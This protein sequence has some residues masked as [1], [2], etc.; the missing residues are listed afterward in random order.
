MAEAVSE[1]FVK[2]GEDEDGTATLLVGKEIFTYFENTKLSDLQANNTPIV[3][4]DR[5]S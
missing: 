3:I 1:D 5:L 2:F 4:H